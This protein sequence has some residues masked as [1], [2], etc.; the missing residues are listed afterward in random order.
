[1]K[2]YILSLD[3]GTTSARAILFDKDSNILAMAQHE[4]G[5]IYPKAG[6]VE[7]DPME[8]YANQYAALTE[9]IAKSGIS[10]DEIAAIG[11]TN[12][13]ETVIVWDKKTGRPIYN[14]IVWQ[15]RRS[16]DIC[17]DLEKNGYSDYIREATGLRLDPYFS[18]TKIKWILDNVENARERAKAG[19][20]IAG[21]VDTWL[22]WKLTDGEVFVT[23][24]T[25]ASR[26]M[27]CNI[28]TGEWDK[29]L[30]DMLDIP[31]SMLP[32]IKSSSEIYGSFECMGAKIPIAGI[33]GDQQAALF[34]QCCFEA[35]E[36]KNTYGTGCFLLTHTG[37]K[38]VMSKNGLLTTIA[39]TEKGRNTEYALEGSV[40][41]GGAVVRWLRDELKLIHESKDSEYFASKVPDCNGVYLV[42]AFSGLGAPHWDMHARGT[43]LG[44]TA[45]AGKNHIIRAALEAIAYQTN[46]VLGAMAE[47]MKA[48][49]G[50]LADG[51]VT[52]LKVDGG[53]SAND[54]L[55]QMQSDISNISVNRSSNPEATAAGAAY[56]AGLAVGFFESREEIKSKV[57]VGKIFT[58]QMSDEVRQKKTEGWQRAI[59]ACRVFES[60]E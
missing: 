5:Q 21:T 56:L 7:Q 11:I 8:I 52:C 27:L 2:K 33:A 35:G 48:M 46:D 41:V 43:I 10:A 53:A 51:D 34:G 16:A 40:F 32:E 25:N 3:E 15:C 24:K 54:L 44:L 14:A 36:A 45:G 6:W 29:K 39:A 58:P 49:G 30:L 37:E 47:D 12:Q 55:M 28:H 1:M 57:G 31:M 50:E 26:T 38:A 13:R 19:E 20:L 60:E 22:I 17:E 18:G 9:C 59:N 42:P 23:D 4:F